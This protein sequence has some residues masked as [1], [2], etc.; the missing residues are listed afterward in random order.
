MSADNDAP[1]RPAAGRP[2]VS[3][4][5]PTRDRPELLHRAVTS[6]LA[7]SFPGDLECIVVFDQS[8]PAPLSFESTAGRQ[9]RVLTNDRTRGLAGARNTGI[10]SGSGSLIAFC[11]D[12]DE[13][14]PDKLSLQADRLQSAEFVV[15]GVRI[16]H[17]GHETVRLPPPEIGLADLVRS[18]ITAVHPSTF[19][20]RRD[21]LIGMGL[22]DEKIPG[23]YGEDYDL[24]MRA[25]RRG[26]IVAVAEPLADVHWHRQSFFAEGWSSRASALEYLLDKHPE[27]AGDRR[28]LARM[29][30][31]IAFAQ[32]AL[33]RRAAA[34]RSSW[35]AIRNNPA[36]RRAYL[37]LA[38]ASG[39]VPASLIMR[40]ANQ[41]GRGI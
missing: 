23:S 2:S 14:H 9:V 20:I 12:D 39:A 3:V 26:P 35:R 21:A 28:G 41:R 34:G 37:A 10:V 31:R 27:F 32:A 24:L 36:E 25:A 7:Q 40:L 22:V 6:I 13:W 18:R 17:A 38:V 8:P 29:Q 4:V 1:R 5:V 19:V 16:H 15:C 11:D 33:Q 30:G